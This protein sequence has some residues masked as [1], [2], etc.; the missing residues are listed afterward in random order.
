MSKE[1]TVLGRKLNPILKV[2]A[3]AKRP[4]LTSQKVTFEGASWHIPENFYPFE[5]LHASQVVEAAGMP[6]RVT[7]GTRHIL[8]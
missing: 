6:A 8:H 1:D 4:S 2:A 5:G 7:Q 3:G